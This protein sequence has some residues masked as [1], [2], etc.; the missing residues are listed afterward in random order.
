MSAPN[1][2]FHSHFFVLSS[3]F[4]FVFAITEWCSSTLGRVPLPSRSGSASGELLRVTIP[5]HGDGAPEVS[6]TTPLV[7]RC[8]I[9]KTGVHCSYIL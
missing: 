2:D 9:Y 1:E 4:T 7:E 3:Q 8:G 5:E 6:S